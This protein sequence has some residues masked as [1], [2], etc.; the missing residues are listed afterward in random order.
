M[1]GVCRLCSKTE[2][3]PRALSPRR[4][5]RSASPHPHPFPKQHTQHSLFSGASLAAAAAASPPPLFLQPLLDA[6]TSAAA[7]LASNSV[8]MAG[9]WAWAAAQVAKVFT[10]RATAG[11]W[12]VS[13]LADSGG[14]PSSHSALAVAV[15]AAAGRT[16]GLASATFAVA[17][18]Y[19][20]V[21]MYDAA[22]VRRHAG[23]QAEV[24]NVLLTDV[25]SALAVEHP[26][27]SRRLKEVLGHTPRQV[28]AGAVL[29]LAVG[30][31]LP[32]APGT[33]VV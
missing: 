9:F 17:L 18:C 14:M 10:K 26:V 22:G 6:L 24:L 12:D 29:G 2:Q 21:V 3:D 15:T 32:L 19:A 30:L 25:V 20:L 28:A 7:A 1:A 4:R 5:R 33:Q 23:K 13:A 16:L 8:F 31:L 27:A 11:V